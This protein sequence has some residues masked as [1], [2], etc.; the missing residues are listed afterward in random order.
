MIIEQEKDIFDCFL[1]IRMEAGNR[2]SNIIDD[3]SS[4]SLRS[5]IIQKYGKCYSRNLIRA[6]R[7]K[8]RKRYDGR[9]S[10]YFNMINIGTMPYPYDESK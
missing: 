10:D 8:I 4:K 1:K 2:P 3:L 5:K 7:Y 9:L 6:V